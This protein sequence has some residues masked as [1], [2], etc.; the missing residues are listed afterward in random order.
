MSSDDGENG[1]GRQRME[2][3]RI[4]MSATLSN[5]EVKE[6]DKVEGLATSEQ[7][8]CLEKAA[9]A[10]LPL[11]SRSSDIAKTYTNEA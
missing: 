4:V 6:G 1:D 3:Y 9:Q 2:T 10:A 11:A 7:F 8:K 5:R